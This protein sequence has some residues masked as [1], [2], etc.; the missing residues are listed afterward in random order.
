MSRF[1]DTYFSNLGNVTPCHYDEQQNFFAEVRGYKRC[2]LF[3]PEQF[4]CLYPHPVYHPHDRQSQVR[5]YFFFWETGNKRNNK[6]LEG[7]FLE[8]FGL[9]SYQ[10]R[11]HM[12]A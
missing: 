3:P 8:C 9:D 7:L 5:I 6:C 1:Y 11:G 12:V 4:E 2:I 10:N